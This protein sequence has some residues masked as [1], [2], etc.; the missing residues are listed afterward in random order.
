MEELDLELDFAIEIDYYE[1]KENN[2]DKLRAMDFEELKTS[3]G[4][5]YGDE[6]NNL[7]DSNKKILKL[8]KGQ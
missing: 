1:K 2:L 4:Y 5:A 3:I 6:L 8:I 7:K